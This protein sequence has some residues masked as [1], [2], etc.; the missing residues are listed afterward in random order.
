V[1]TGGWT[2]AL[3]KTTLQ[4]TPGNS[5]G[6]LF[7][8]FNGRHVVIGLAQSLSGNGIDVS[9]TSPN[10]QV[11]FTTGTLRLIA[12]AQARYPCH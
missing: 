11:L 2:A 7:G 9:D 12:A 1:T 10:V 5:G 3:L 8:D 4:T 6:P